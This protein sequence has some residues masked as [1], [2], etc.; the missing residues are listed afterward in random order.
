M[1]MQESPR[2]DALPPLLDLHVRLVAKCNLNCKHCYASD[3]FVRS[4]VLDVELVKRAIDEA[5]PLGLEKVTFTGGEPTLHPQLEAM[6][7]HCVE[8]GLPAKVET[9][10]L[11]L[12]RPGSRIRELLIEHRDLLKVYI[13]Y[14]LAEQR[15]LT[16]D[17][18]R[19]LREVVLDLHRNG[20]RVKVQSALTQIN[21]HR[22]DELLE[23]AREHGVPQRFFF[24][25]TVLGNATG[26]EPFD[27][28]TVLE[29]YR[30]L[31][32]LDLDLDCELPPLLTGRVAHTCGWGLNRCE[33]MA[34]GDVTT[35]GPVTFTKTGFIAGSLKDRPLREIWAQS[36]FFTGM[37]EI[38]QS[39][40]EG[41]CGQCRY[42]EDCR[43]SCRAYAWSKGDDWFSPYPLCQLYAERHPDQ[44]RPHLYDLDRSLHS[45]RPTTRLPR[46]EA[47]ASIDGSQA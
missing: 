4:D 3:W 21:I 20:V 19:Q 24:D 9:N 15:E 39:D 46:V 45:G 35:C 41:V 11:L 33:L 25:P 47:I 14:D 2:G 36:D 23:L 12:S 43:G 44:A 7:L 29:T 18:H 8:R 16:D 13:S 37:R 17:E 28:D 6:L 1:T 5:I 30:Y 38:Q 40:F 10:G 34:N 42:W 27:L 22:L 26:L 31:E 32:S